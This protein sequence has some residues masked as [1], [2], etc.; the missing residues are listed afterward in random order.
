MIRYKLFFLL[1]LSIGFFTGPILAQTCSISATANPICEGASSTL[2]IN[3]TGISSPI[4]Y[5]WDNLLTT[6][7]I[8]VSPTSTTPYFCIVSNGTVTCTTAV[9]TLT[10]NPTP[11][12]TNQTQTICS[13][14]TFTI[15]PSTGSGNSVPIGTSYSWSAPS[16]SGITGTAPGSSASSISGTLTNT[17]NAAINVVYNVTPTS[18]SCPGSIFTVT[19]TVNPTPNVT[20][21]TQTICSAGT[22]T[23][24]P[25]NGS[26][27]IVPTGTSYSWSAPSVSGITGTAPGSSASSISGT[28]TNTTNAAIN[29]VYNVTPTSGSCPGSIFTVTVTVNPTPNVTNQTQTICSAGTFTISPS[30]GSGNIVPTGTS[31]S[32]SASSV[33]GITGTAS[34]SSASSISGTLTNTTNAAINVVYNVTPTSG[35]CPGSIFTVTV[36]VKPMPSIANN[37]QSVCSNANYLGNWTIPDIVPLN[38][39]YTWSVTNNTQVIGETNNTI[40][41]TF[42][43]T[44]TNLTLLNQSVSYTITPTI[45]GCTGLPFTLILDVKPAPNSNA[46]LD[47]SKTCIQNVSGAMIGASAIPGYTYA[48]TP[49]S[50][51]SA[52]TISNP[53]AN[54]A[55]TTIYTITV[56]DPLSSC[57]SQDSVMVT[58]NNS[59]PLASAGN[60]GFITCITNPS[61]LLIGTGSVN[62]IAYSWFPTNGLSN[63]NSSQT[64]AIPLTNTTYSLTAYN[65]V[66]GCTATDQ[67]I[68]TVD[69][70]VPLANAG[71]DF[72]KTCILSPNGAAIGTTAVA[73][74]TYSWSP[75]TGLTSA[76]AANPIANPTATTTYTLTATNTAS[77]CTA[78]DQVIVT[79]NNAIPLAYAGIDLTISCNQ[80]VNG[81]VIGNL[82]EAGLQ[83]S[84]SP[85]NGLSNVNSSQ[86]N[87]MPSATTPYSLTAYNPVN[88]CTASDLVFVTVNNA[89]PIANAGSDFTKT[90]ILNPNGAPIGTTAV[91]GNTYSWSP[92]TNLT[93]SLAASTTANP[94]TT[95]TYTLT[96]TNTASGCTATDQVLVIVNNAVPLAN[97]GADFTKTCT[98]NPNGT[99]IGTT[100]VA[101]NTYSWAPTTNLTSSFAASTTANPSF[102]TPYTLTATN[103]ASGCTAT[104]Q[105]VVTVNNSL[106]TVNAGTNDTICNGSSVALSGGSNANNILWTPSSLVSNPG[107][108]A[109][110]ANIQGTTTFT[111]TATGL[112]G[113][114]SSDF[115]IITVNDLPQSGL[116]NNY[117]ICSNE[118]LQLNVSPNL[119]CQWSG[120]LDSTLNS[121]NQIVDSSG[122]IFLEIT[123]TNNCSTT[124]EITI[125]L[126]PIPY[127]IITGAAQVCQNSYWVEYSVPST[128]NFIQWSILNGEFLSPNNS[129][130]V[131]AH[132]LDGNGKIL[133]TETIAAT[134]CNNEYFINVLIDSLAL[135]LDTTEILML[136]SNVLYTPQDYPYMNWG[137][138]S[139]IT[140]IP[141]SIGV[142]SQYCNFQNIDLSNY[143]YW[144]EIGEGNGCITKSYFNPPIFTAST[145]ENVDENIRIYP[146]PATDMVQFIGN[147]SQ[148][149]S[150][151]LID[152]N[153]QIICQNNFDF[154]DTLDVSK[155]ESGIYFILLEGLIDK[156]TIKF[157]KI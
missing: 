101:G 112:N 126:L 23:I 3:T 95:T 87:A 123:D 103:T 24:S 81:A 96:T 129:N 54:P 58:V 130:V 137:Y 121:I 28:L 7:T 93:S 125:N 107:S 145:I 97:A 85:T 69:N 134:G 20:N 59:V 122:T 135:A 13:A 57:S 5:A 89:P 149:N 6:N 118:N 83:Y 15:S 140:H 153:G 154:T 139:I 53:I 99:A 111:L 1:F 62:G 60:D 100:A 70:S 50:G 82:P 76:T 46:G 141:I 16:V 147:L 49:T 47:F 115:V 21:Q 144:V 105:V 64:N 78:T 45:N 132:W 127:P 42:G 116:S 43:Q 27:N 2:G 104:D 128:S 56:S 11:N 26:G 8:N 41:Q 61:G 25:S 65:P 108:L 131:F 38:T 73:G 157:F 36:I 37:S 109:P 88:G 35:S 148:F 4:S 138:E 74:N 51:L 106:P 146:N 71:A 67:V 34:G 110:S 114:T 63:A 44:L 155:L 68:V 98:L 113:C 22:F 55:S 124:E 133:V 17:T 52:S 29:V 32:W 33:S 102:S 77:G 156:L 72:T 86:T 18:G 48:W 79:V 84:W 80:N 9:F 120:L 31:Y 12:V 66:N 90:C 117:E 150:C 136:S 40:P 142:Q 94:S 119:T 92:T 152:I 143:N 151:K 30:N 19:V 10:V 91:A 14:G 39:L 75:S